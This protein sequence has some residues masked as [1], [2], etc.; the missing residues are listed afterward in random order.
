MQAKEPRFLLMDIGG[1]NT[2]F[3]VITLPLSKIPQSII[4]TYFKSPNSNPTQPEPEKEQ[5]ITPILFS[6]QNKRDFIHESDITLIYSKNYLSQTFIS[7]SQAVDRFFHDAPKELSLSPESLILT[8]A[9]CGPVTNQKINTMSNLNWSDIDSEVL[10]Q[11]GF[12]DVYITNDFEAF[13]YGLALAGE[14]N[15][16]ELI[17]GGR[18]LLD[19]EGNPTQMASEFG[20]LNDSEPDFD[21]EQFHQL[22]SKTLLAVGVG[23]GVG[24][25][26][27]KLHKS[28]NQNKM[29]L[30][31]IPSEAGHSYFSPKQNPLDLELIRFV[32][33]CRG[34]DP[35]SEYV[36]FEFLISSL[37]LPL[38]FDFLK[39]KNPDLKI[40]MKNPSSIQI[41]ELAKESDPLAQ[42]TVEYYIDLLGQFV[43]QTAI[44]FLPEI[45]IL[46]SNCMETLQAIIKAK[47]E[48]KDIFWKSFLAKSH[49]APTHQK[50]PVYSF[51]NEKF[52]LT[53][54]GSLLAY[55]ELV[56]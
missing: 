17:F 44:T 54:L 48:L 42:K 10:K 31:V 53:E 40:A 26:A 52:N 49:M 28:V 36:P 19:S 29:L 15:Q 32:G 41:W 6:A 11:K 47:P 20:A 21:I 35:Q 25:V 55:F 8:M 9:C 27:L 2:R 34:I 5:E 45:V 39:S 56:R 7:L 13:G 1:T 23:T 50:I 12:L 16:I 18:D 24:V 51:K 37:S 46:K 33:K 30:E 4:E 22:T 38:I 14:T 3:K 43:H